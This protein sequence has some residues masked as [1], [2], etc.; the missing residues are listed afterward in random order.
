M[1]FNTISCDFALSF[2]IKELSI[3]NFA[4]ID[5][6]NISFSDGLTILSGETGAGKSII[7]NA[8][9]LLLGSRANATLIRTGAKIAELETLFQILPDSNVAKLMDHH[10]YDSKDGLLVR[11]IISRSDSNRVYI[12]GRL[13]TM[14]LLNAMTK[15]LASIS[16]QHVHQ[17]LLKEDQQL[18]ILDQFGSLMPL[19]RKIFDYFHE[20]LPL[21]AKLEAL[22]VARE[23]QAEHIELIKFQKKEIM[24]ASIKLAED[25]ELEGERIRLK[26]GELLYQTVYDS[27][28]ELY[29]VQ[30]SIMERLAQVKTNLEK[31]GQIDSKLLQKAET[32]TEATYQV[33]D[34]VEEL[35]SYLKTIQIDE[36][37]LEVVEERLD[38]LHKI[39]RKYGGSLETVFSHLES[40]SQELAGVENISDKISETE[41]R[42]SELHGK[43]VELATQLSDKRKETAEILSKKVMA[44]LDTL[45]MARTEFKALLQTNPVDETTDHHLQVNSS[46]LNET[47]LD[48]A[49]FLIAPNVGEML[50][51][52]SSIASGGELSRVVLA[53]KAILAATDSVG[54]VVFDEV[55]AG[56]GGG[57][58]EVVGQKLSELAKH[59]QVICITHLPQIAKFGDHHFNISKSVSRGRT[60]T[61]ISPLSEN[62]RIDEI[63]RMLGGVKITQKT[64]DHAREMLKR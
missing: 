58:A 42:L 38:T 43:L 18:L 2:M 51:P 4:I 1:G 37:R 29:S 31:A 34:I 23:R 35:R 15:N 22:K 59:H 8:V 41:T 14:Q 32:L 11:R 12:N 27:V 60:R 53:L 7:L 49:T 39:K 33:E 13:A 3:R 64:L 19:R 25:T 46:A 40:I 36:K 57:V 28:E 17:G 56:I 55:D 48:R 30:G 24:E 45:R 20:M 5:D 61:T 62:E 63:A 44:E 6:L 52:L 9:N 50:K 10:G 26:H 54:T 47:G 21:L 16:G